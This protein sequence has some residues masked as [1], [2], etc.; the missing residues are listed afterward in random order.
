MQCFSHAPEPAIGTCKSCGRGICRACA[1]VLDAGLACSEACATEVAESHEM[2][3]R[4]KR[5][6]GIGKSAA[7]RLPLAALMW[8]GFAL[9]FGGVAL[10]QY[11]RNGIVDW[12]PLLFGLLCA[13]LGVATYR[14]A[15]DLQLNC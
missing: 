11:L 8:A 9:L 3:R 1:Q 14:R 12:F 7:Q 13:I 2:N 5:I 6:Y 10:F 15:R 4:A